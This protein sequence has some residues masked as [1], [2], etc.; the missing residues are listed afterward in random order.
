VILDSG[1]KQVFK[2]TADIVRA[3][4]EIQ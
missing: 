2:G 1:R 3:I 4:R